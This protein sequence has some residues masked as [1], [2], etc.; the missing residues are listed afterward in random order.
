MK[1]IFAIALIATL[2]VA[3]SVAAGEN[4]QAAFQAVANTED[5]AVAALLA[6]SIPASAEEEQAMWKKKKNQRK[7]KQEKNNHKKCCIKYVTITSTPVCKPTPTKCP[8]S[9]ENVYDPIQAARVMAPPAAI[10]L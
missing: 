6:T 10:P 5:E 4:P 3:S 1:N 9:D 7:H 8:F 2:A